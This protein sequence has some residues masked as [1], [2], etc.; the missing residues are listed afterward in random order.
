MSA[1]LTPGT[2]VWYSQDLL[3]GERGVNPPA[4]KATVVEMT[5]ESGEGMYTVRVYSIRLSDGV[6]V[7]AFENELSPAAEG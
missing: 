6:V 5:G 1:P 2:P 4:R 3:G 7:S